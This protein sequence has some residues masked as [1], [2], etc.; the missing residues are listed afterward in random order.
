MVIVYSNN[1]NTGEIHAWLIETDSYAKAK[2]IVEAHIKTRGLRHSVGWYDTQGIDV[3]HNL[4]EI[5]IGSE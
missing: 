2:D 1:S 3:L 5:Q 4:V